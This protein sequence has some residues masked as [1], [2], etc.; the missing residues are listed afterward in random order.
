MKDILLDTARTHPL[1]A[2]MGEM[3]SVEN[4][5]FLL[6]VSGG[7]DSMCLLHA[8][9]QALREL[10]QES[11]V[12]S[13]IAVAHVDHALRDTS[14]RDVQFVQTQAE[15]LGLT[16]FATRLTEPARGDNI[17]AWA[18]R[19]RYKFFSS[20][21]DVG[22][23]DSVLTAH[24]GGD[25]LETFLMRILS[26]KEPRAIPTVNKQLRILRPLLSFKKTDIL[27]YAEQFAVPFVEDETNLDTTR[28]RNSVRRSLI[29]LLEQEFG[30]G[31]SQRLTDQAASLERELQALDDIAQKTILENFSSSV[32]GTR[33]WLEV[34][35]NILATMPNP[36]GE[37]V[38]KALFLP[39]SRTPI[40]RESANRLRE[41]LLSGEVAIQLPGALEIRRRKG[42]ISVSSKL[43]A[44]K[45]AEA[46]ES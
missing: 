20:V 18:R 25:Y 35:K 23:Y 14:K 13:R 45:Q 41:F 33:E 29:P 31:V 22:G 16:V 8:S 12:S 4:H 27:A 6:A 30:E 26:N 36:I 19:E 32:F 1:V 2:H 39:F 21:M 28:L 43:T 5:R 9:V 3:F 42:G 17:E 34:L 44:V 7:V 46:R 40:G 11:E 38:V 10:L 24:H 15:A 37:R